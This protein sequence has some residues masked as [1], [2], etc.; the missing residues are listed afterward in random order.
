MNFLDYSIG[1]L[2]DLGPGSYSVYVPKNYPI[3]LLRRLIAATKSHSMGISLSQ[4]YNQYLMDWNPT[5]DIIVDD[6]RTSLLNQIYENVIQF[7]LR[8]LK[9]LSEN[10]KSFVNLSDTNAFYFA[11]ATIMRLEMSFKMS[12]QTLR[13]G[14]PYDA[15]ALLKL[16][17]EQTCWAYSV[18]NIQDD[19]FM[20]IK[21]NSAISIAKKEFHDVGILYGKINEYAHLSP[22]KISELFLHGKLAIKMNDNLKSLEVLTSL[23]EILDLYCIVFEKM[24]CDQA[25]KKHYI[26]ENRSVLKDRQ[27]IRYLEDLQSQIEVYTF[28]LKQYPA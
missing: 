16:I 25:F 26:D 18:F 4:T 7:T 28:K 23:I 15:N 3:E 1:E 13:F 22:E 12:V 2:I 17:L 14:L 24:Y 5:E 11:E 19:S 20:K 9:H 27:T 8:T 6:L 21:P 10:R